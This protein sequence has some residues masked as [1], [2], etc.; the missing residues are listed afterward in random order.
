MSKLKT[1]LN[2]INKYDNYPTK[3]IKKLSLVSGYN[4]NRFILDLVDTLGPEKSDDFVSKALDKLSD[5]DKGIR[6]NLNNDQYVYII[7]ID[8]KIDEGEETV[9]I[10]DKWGDTKLLHSD[11]NGNKTYQTIFEI[12]DDFSSE[13]RDW[14]IFDNMIDNIRDEFSSIVYENCGFHISWY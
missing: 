5:G 4:L 9:A 12:Y 7:I 3:N 10:Q 13:N 1:F 8:S 11:E 6:V 14:G 2:V